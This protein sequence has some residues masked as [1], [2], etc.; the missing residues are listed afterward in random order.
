M[1]RRGGLQPGLP[2]FLTPLAAQGASLR[3]DQGG[4]GNKPGDPGLDGF[5]LQSIPLRSPVPMSPAND[6]QSPGSSA[7]GKALWSTIQRDWL[8]RGDSVGGVGPR[9]TRRSRPRGHVVSTRSRPLGLSRCHP[10]GIN[11]SAFM[12]APR[13]GFLETD[14]EPV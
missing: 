7:V 8:L 12:G 14:L 3:G 6:I 11:C 4:R 5:Q 9:S 2:C 10:S 13:Q 1:K